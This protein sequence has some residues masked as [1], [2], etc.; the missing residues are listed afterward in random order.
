VLNDK[1]E[2]G[3]LL[4]TVIALLQILAKQ[5]RLLDDVLPCHED[6]KLPTV[7]VIVTCL[8]QVYFKGSENFA[9]QGL[10]S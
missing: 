2:L 8:T 4:R 9:F 7:C 5:F 3:M 6:C 10:A 1:S